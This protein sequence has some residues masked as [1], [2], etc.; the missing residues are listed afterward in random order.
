MKNALEIKKGINRHNLKLKIKKGGNMIFE[1]VLSEDKTKISKTEYNK[2]KELSILESEASKLQQEK[3]DAQNSL[4]IAKTK[5]LEEQIEKLNNK[6]VTQRP[7]K[8]PQNK[9]LTL[10]DAR[11]N[12][13]FEILKNYLKDFKEGQVINF[14]E[15]QVN[16]SAEL[17]HNLKK[18]LSVS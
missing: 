18:E 7:Q 12:L 17:K 15:T 2:Q 5:K 11:E 1:N 4:N 10:E 14:L 9:P 8:E 13:Q 6:I 3:T 16:L